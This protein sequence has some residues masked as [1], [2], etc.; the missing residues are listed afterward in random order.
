[1]KVIALVGCYLSLLLTGQLLW[2][3]GLVLQ[4][5]LFE[6]GI[7]VA[8]INLASSWHIVLGVFIYGFATLIWLYLLSRYDFSYIYPITS[9]SFVLGIFLSLVLLG[10]TIPWNRWLGV[11]IIC[12]GVYLVSLR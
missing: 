7:G 6:A 2:K 12:S 9:L 5:G 8:L 1:M 10:E 3:K 11:A 4:P